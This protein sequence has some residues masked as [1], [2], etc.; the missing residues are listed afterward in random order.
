MS[1]KI[2]LDEIYAEYVHLPASPIA[3][4]ISFTTTTINE[5]LKIKKKLRYTFLKNG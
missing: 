5:K 2:G 3:T 4:N 1:N